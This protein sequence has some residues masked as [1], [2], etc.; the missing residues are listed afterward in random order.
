MDPRI[1]RTRVL[2][3]L[4]A[5]P[6]VVI[7]AGL[8]AA[9]FTMAVVLHAPLGFLGFLGLSGILAGVGIAVTRSILGWDELTR[10]AFD[11][12][13]GESDQSQAQIIDGLE[14]A[15]RADHDPR[16]TQ[17]AQELRR[18]YRRLE[19]AGVMGDNIDS[20]L[21]PE[22]K[23]K[24]EQLYQS[25][26]DSLGRT[27]ELWQAA[28]EMAT[29]EARK[30]VLA[31]REALIGEV[32]K[33]VHHLGKTLDHLQTS[34]LKRDRQDEDLARMRE[35]LEMGLQVAQRVEQRIDQLGQLDRANSPE[36][37][38]GPPQNPGANLN[39]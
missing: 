16:T 32:D 6:L 37:E 15:L 25:C 28:Q 36:Q 29:P 21:L 1:Y 23:N 11:E 35:E 9:T 5:S 22:I 2:K 33:S 8:G 19:R 14:Q 18:L 17:S 24:A 27:L 26:L 12:L 39:C 31:Q 13:Q 20:L 4:I 30:Q 3:E 34:M 10:R 7:P 38:G